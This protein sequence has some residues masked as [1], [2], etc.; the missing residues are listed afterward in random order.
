VS[1][2]AALAAFRGVRYRKIAPAEMGR[3]LCPPYDVISQA[4]QAELYDRHPYNAVR[5]EFGKTSLQDAPD[6]NRYTRAAATWRQWLAEGVLGCEEAP[7]IYLH[8]QAFALPFGTPRVPQGPEGHGEMRQR[9]GLFCLVRLEEFERRLVL[10][11][12]GT[13]SAPKADRLELMRACQAQLS[14]ALMLFKDRSGSAS[15][16]LGAMC[17]GEPLVRAESAGESHTLWRCG[18]QDWIG[19]V[20]ALLDEGP[21]FI[22]DGHHRYETALNFRNEMRARFPEAPGNAAFNYVLALLVNADDPGLVILPTHRLLRLGAE[23]QVVLERLVAERFDIEPVAMGATCKEPAGV[24][25]ESLLAEQAGDG[26]AYA[27]YTAGGAFRLLKPKDPPTAGSPTDVLDVRVL[28]ERLLDV[29]LSQANQTLRIKYLT[30]A[31]AAIAAVDSGEY[32]SA[33]LLNPTPVEQVLEA[34]LAGE[35]MP[36]KSTYFYP[37]A[38]TGLVMSPVGP[39]DRAEW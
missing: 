7:S 6:D 24:H 33:F 34:G 17:Q 28:H 29:V 4:Q 30:D 32:Q 25:V 16:L 31:G 18:R 38:P 39:E 15:R 23:D 13:L 5:L 2:A 19:E 9:G 3:V 8:R 37:K 35:R 1:E 36:G 14:P 12:E 21:F 27:W 26:T 10:P 11:H 20:F 22:A